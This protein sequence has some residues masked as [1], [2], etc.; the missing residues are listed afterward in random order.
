MPQPTAVPPYL[1]TDRYEL[2]MIESLR[3]SGRL[4]APAVFEAFTR[5]LPAGRSYGMFVGADRLVDM[6]SDFRFDLD[7]IQWL[8]EEDVIGVETADWL[9]DFRFTATVEGLAEGDLYF[10][11]TPVL[12]VRGTYAEGLLVETLLLSVINHDC[13]VASA[14]S[15]M[16]SAARGL[17]II[18]MGSRRV[19]EQ[20]AVDSARAAYIAGFASTSNLAAHRRYGIPSAG[21]AAHAYTLGHAGLGTDNDP[22][23]ER[24]AFYNQ[25]IAHGPDTSMLI[26]TY[27]IVDGVR[28]AVAATREAHP[29]VNGPGAVRI[30]SGDLVLEAKRVRALLGELGAVDTRIIVTSDIDEHAITDILSFQAPVDGFGA[31]TRVATGSGHPTAG[32][33]YKLVEI[34]GHAVAKKANGKASVGGAK[35]VWRTYD[36]NAKIVS[37]DHYIG[38]TGPGEYTGFEIPAQVTWMR[39]G[40]RARSATLD[41]ARRNAERS[42][43]NLWTSL[44]AADTDGPAVTPTVHEI[45]PAVV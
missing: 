10:P 21:T 22:T 13:A 1:L 18:E 38:A 26:D 16:V 30:D 42:R 4:D 32:F 29:G 11:S 33:V 35:H 2:S 3:A 23:G 39:N 28:N 8:W 34:D 36:A 9:R 45:A 17:P 25:A 15:R 31:G 14:A 41:E 24:L 6:L 27:N 40:A 37:E 12:T 44:L 19:H 20:A 43:A 7:E 5:R